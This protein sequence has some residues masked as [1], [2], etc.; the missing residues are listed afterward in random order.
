MVETLRELTE[1]MIELQMLLS[2][3]EADPEVVKDTMESVMFDFENKLDDYGTVIRNLEGQMELIA[4]EIKRLQKKK[5]YI[6]K[7]KIY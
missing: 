1:E 7:I 5:K 6:E 2:D 3:D 4:S